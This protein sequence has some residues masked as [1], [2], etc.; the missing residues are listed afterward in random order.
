MEWHKDDKNITVP[1]N[2]KIQIEGYKLVIE[3]PSMEDMGNYSCSTV[4]K[5]NG[6]K[7]GEQ[8]IIVIGKSTISFVSQNSVLGSVS[9]SLWYYYDCYDS[10][11]HHHHYLVYAVYLYIYS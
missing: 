2:S 10:Y 6:K 7:T 9:L 1:Q 11:Y 8:T 5:Y 3:K 4:D